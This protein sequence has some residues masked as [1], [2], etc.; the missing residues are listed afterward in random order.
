ML[1]A[2]RPRYV[3]FL[4]THLIFLLSII[5]HMFWRYSNWQARQEMTINPEVKLTF[6]EVTET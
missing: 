5:M 4:R 1:L 2:S 6:A 3:T